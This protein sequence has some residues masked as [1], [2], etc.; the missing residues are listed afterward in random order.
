MKMPSV[1]WT[2][3]RNKSASLRMRK[4]SEKN[5]QKLWENF[6]ICAFRI[7]EGE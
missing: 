6:N 2:Q 7:L 3:P 1:D 4:K 5:I